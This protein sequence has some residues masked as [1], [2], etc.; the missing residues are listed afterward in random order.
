MIPI[1][2]L[3]HQLNPPRSLNKMFSYPG[4]SYK[5]LFTFITALQPKGRAEEETESGNKINEFSSS[6]YCRNSS[7][8]WRRLHPVVQ[9]LAQALSDRRRTGQ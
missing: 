1:P 6:C 9:G 8:N 7:E 3:I 4:V 2:I 5:Q